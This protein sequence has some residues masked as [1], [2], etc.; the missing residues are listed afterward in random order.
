MI[1]E[2]I[3]H[4][5]RIYTVSFDNAM[6]TVATGGDDR[7]AILWDLATGKLRFRLPHLDR[8]LALDFHPITFVVNLC[9]RKR[10]FSRQS[11]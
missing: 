8:I 2:L 1:T 7:D 4:N 11:R 9:N 6:Q 10:Q 5:D 3:G